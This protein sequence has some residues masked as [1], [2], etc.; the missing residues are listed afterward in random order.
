MKMKKSIV[1]MLTL[2]LMF[3]LSIPALATRELPEPIEAASSVT[4]A[5]SVDTPE[6][7][8]ANDY[9]GVYDATP[10]P[11]EAPRLDDGEPGRGG[12]DDPGKYWDE[13]GYPENVSYAFEGGGEL[14]DDGT[15]VSWWEIGV[16]GL[17]ENSKNA[18][19][20]LVSPDCRV[21]FYDC[22]YP[23]SQRE[24]AYNE[25]LAQSKEDSNILNVV[26]VSNTEAVIVGIAEGYE[27]EYAAALILKYGSF[28][29]VTDDKYFSAIDMMND[30]NIMGGSGNDTGIYTTGAKT[31]PGGTCFWWPLCILA[32]LGL[33][34]LLFFNRTRWVPALQTA[35]GPVITQGGP[36]SAKETVRAVKNSETAPDDSVFDDVMKRIEERE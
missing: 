27:K 31:G 24:A 12:V 35:R 32:M 3:F 28:V 8:D 13:N 14:L 30:L 23:Y 16:V 7:M 18:I 11:V 6:P 22:Q 15:V 17:D 9:E 29:T 34:A 33:A 5:P 10:E 4:F 2:L 36:V 1:C 19:L 21:T 26:M 25:I 20:N